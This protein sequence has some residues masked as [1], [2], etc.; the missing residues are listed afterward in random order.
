VALAEP[1]SLTAMAFEHRFEDGELAGH[2]LGNLMLAGLVDAAG[3]LVTGIDEAAALL[4]AA[5]RVLPATTEP[6]VLKAE[7]GDGEVAGQVAVSSAGRIRRVSLVPADSHP[8]P[9]AIE[10]L[11]HA[12][13]VIIGPGSL[14]TSVLAAAAIPGIAEAI[15]HTAARRIYVCNLHPQEPET[16]GYDV[17]AHVRA[18]SEHAVPIDV[19][20]CDTSTGMTLDGLDELD[21]ADMEVVDV[22]L[23]THGG[24][25]HDPGR[26]AEALS[27]LLA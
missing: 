3:D 22:P 8:P 1:G 23:S 16:S 13:Q 2:A 24:Y 21:G 5:G 25:A 19:V 4:G 17:A 26:L 12:D 18:L 10:A 20:L 7:A 9:E 6:V 15:Q 14:Y 27:G 11:R